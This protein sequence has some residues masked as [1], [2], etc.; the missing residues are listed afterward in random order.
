MTDTISRAQRVP[1][2]LPTF[3]TPAH[4]PLFPAH[5]GI[6]WVAYQARH[7]TISDPSRNNEHAEL[8]RGFP[9]NIGEF[10]NE[11]PLEKHRLDFVPT[12]PLH[13][14]SVNARFTED[15]DPLFASCH[16]NDSVEEYASR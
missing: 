2:A 4:W 13:L 7:L 16:M 12:S 1:T 8:P 14:L 15:F 10:G 6:D 11:F 9:R 5:K 3:P